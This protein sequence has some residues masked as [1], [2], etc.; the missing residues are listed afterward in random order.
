[1]TTWNK[2]SS[3]KI[4]YVSINKNS[5]QKTNEI[6]LKPCEWLVILQCMSGS[7]NIINKLMP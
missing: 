3:S 5:A 1:M 4:R 2:I 6:V 7:N